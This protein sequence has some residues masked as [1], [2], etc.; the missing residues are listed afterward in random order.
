MNAEQHYA[1]QAKQLYERLKK[2]KPV[3]T[4]IQD[5]KSLVEFMFP[6]SNPIEKKDILYALTHKG[7]RY[8]PAWFR[9]VFPDE[10]KDE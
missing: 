2:V 4:H 3:P 5:L 9:S 8:K 10:C 1:G 7:R 6:D